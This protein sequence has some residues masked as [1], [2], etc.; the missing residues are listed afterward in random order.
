VNEE[1]K[2][3]VRVLYISPLKALSN[4]IARN[5]ETPLEELRELAHLKG[6]N[7]PEIRAQV[8]TGDTSGS[9]RQKMLKKPPQILVTTPESLFLLLTS[10]KSREILRTVKTVIV[11]E[12]HALAGNKRG[13]HLSL[14]L[15][16]L[17][18][19]CSHKPT[20]IG[21][22]ATQKPMETIADYLVGSSQ[23][24]CSIVDVGQQKK[25][26][27]EI[28]VPA[29]ELSAVCSHE[30]WAEVYQTVG[31][32]VMR[33][34]STLIFVNT[35]KLAE[36]VTFHLSEM[37]GEHCIASHH[38]S[39]SKEKRLE[40]ELRLKEGKLKAI[41]AT[42]SMELG[43]DIGYV[44]LVCQIGS[45]RRISAFLQRVG[46]SGH[47]VEAVPRGRLFAL[48]RDELIECLA[49]ISGVR[50]G[51]LDEIQ[52][53]DQ[54]LDILA[55]QIIAASCEQEWDLE[56]IYSLCKGAY[57]YRNLSL[58][59]F[60]EVCRLF[61]GGLGDLNHFPSYLHYDVL[62][63]KIRAK[64]AA[65]ISA[66]TNAG[67]IPEQPLYRVVNIE[68][69]N[70]V[71]TVDEDFALE[72]PA[73][74]VFLLGNTSW[75][76]IHTRGTQVS[77]RD[78]HGAPPTI[79]FWFGEAPGRSLELS[80]LV[81]EIRDQVAQRLP[82]SSNPCKKLESVHSAA[83]LL[84]LRPE[85]VEP[86]LEFLAKSVGNAEWVLVQAVFYIAAQKAAM[87]RV[88][89]QEEVVFERFFDT[90]GGMQLVIHAPF[91]IQ[92]NRAWGL[93]LR[94]R[95][96]RSFD[97][98]L[99]A[100]ADDEGIILSLG[101]NQSFP[102]EQLFGFLNTE[103][104]R[105]LLEQAFLQ[106]PYFKTRWQWNATRSLAVLRFRGGK[107]VPPALQKMRG[108][109]LLTS[110][111]PD[112]NQCL[113]HISG[114][115]P[116]PYDHPLVGETMENCL[117]EVSDLSGLTQV[118]EDISRKKIKLI[119]MDTREP[120]PFS[121]GRLNAAPYAFLDNA[122]LEER[123]TR[124][125]AQ[126][127]ELSIEELKDLGAL[128]LETLEQVRKDSW[129]LVRD[130]DELYEALME[131]SLL[132]DR[133]LSPWKPQLRS[134]R[135]EQRAFSFI[136]QGMEFHYGVERIPVL[137]AAYELDSLPGEERLPV[138]L[139]NPWE[140]TD[141]IQLL[142]R[143]R[144]SV[145]PVLSSAEIADILSLPEDTVQSNLESI[146][147]QGSILRG[148]FL[149]SNQI[150]WC[151]RRLLQRIHKLTIEGLRKKI[152]PVDTRTFL[153]F[154]FRFHGLTKGEGLGSSRDLL[155]V[156][157]QLQGFEAACSE[158]ESEILPSRI[159]NFDPLKLD[160]LCYQ[161]ILSWGR[162]R[163]PKSNTSKGGM[164]R[165]VPISFFLR[166]HLSYL[167]ALQPGSVS[168]ISTSSR[169]NA[170]LKV[171]EEHG[172]QFSSELSSRTNLLSSELEE[173]LGELVRVG[174]VN[175]DGFSAIRPYISEEA[176]KRE[177]R[178]Q[179]YMRRY[180]LTRVSTGGRWNLFPPATETRH[181][182]EG[183]DFW[184][185][186]LL[187]RWGIIFRDILSQESGA[188][189]WMELVKVYRRL[190]LR[191]EI[192]GGR[193]ISS[194]GG[195]QFALP[196]SVE[197]LRRFRDQIS[198]RDWVV[199]SSADPLNLTGILFQTS[200]I[201]STG[202][203]KLLYCSG[204]LT[205]ILKRKSQVEFLVP[206]AADLKEEMVLF[207]RS[208]PVLRKT[209]SIQKN[210]ERINPGYLAQT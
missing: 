205:A 97:F 98:E 167:L 80:T 14:S 108:E 82:N 40:A 113:E 20:R 47:A 119:P 81:S 168:Q 93:A 190:E 182:E 185:W 58:D 103:N 148:N 178:K 27:L 85:S 192:R 176:K 41:V 209:L 194:V 16:R 104:I 187:Q 121:Y 57:P 4:D 31:D 135:E 75:Q 191:G 9:H 197:M 100:L 118:L 51:I 63:K 208:R 68:E 201:P 181:R 160:E 120:S 49:L 34:R 175:A 24:Q 111:F 8:R 150:Q 202:A 147:A 152:K 46:R 174:M 65:R 112:V 32:L 157:N 36:R 110:S 26:D 88:P 199:I 159:E 39:L 210:H 72:R 54:P 130:K 96:C 186:L 198:P 30:Q 132:N 123:R 165:A 6:E 52:V 17:D 64:R 50:Q 140:R 42:A 28:Q 48:T 204:V 141:A 61:A 193:F 83:E 145:Q 67:A 53:P 13:A 5:L 11:D 146:E 73:G 74:H 99:Q 37:L 29:T 87:G 133:D 21:L 15:E 89:T 105:G 76:I 101:A 18:H 184:A 84:A 7:L 134:L 2:E 45:P 59:R 154:L 95:F 69:G 137:K 23:K 12:I 143:A 38:G 128:D 161:G 179:S 114:D 62:N 207:L 25:L 71:G 162:I 163:P 22:S 206:V 107:K 91:G 200:R 189:P 169:S 55:Q 171:L 115:I 44:D 116:I 35:R 129:P 195:E 60:V 43:I 183:M 139:Q 94:K 203:K 156:F 56:E 188:P 78:A 66:L 138:E 136:Y 126:R 125:L 151:E 1:A 70:F 172:A 153:N 144:L 33:H 79:P 166:E 196:Q 149:N 77:V 180:S 102:I 106:A 158:W 142:I 124:A 117:Y 3:G 122:P 127:R 170:V 90:S 177:K 173:S 19:L 86:A 164:H 131:L 10:E 155:E 92:I 109:D